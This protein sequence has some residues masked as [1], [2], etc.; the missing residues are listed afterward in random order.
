MITAAAPP[1]VDCIQWVPRRFA[2]GNAPTTIADLVF[3]SGVFE[4]IAAHLERRPDESG[5]GALVGRVF[6]DPTCE[7]RWARVDGIVP[8]ERPLAEEA[9]A[10]AIAG[11]FV[12][13]A[14]EI[15]IRDGST[16]LGWYRLHVGT[17]LYLSPEEARFHEARF[18]DPWGFALILAG[19]AER[20]SG[21]VFQRTVRDG[22]SRSVYT[23]FYELSGPAEGR[24]PVARPT[25]LAWGNYQTETRVVRETSV[26]EREPF[27]VAT[28]PE[29]DPAL[30][31]GQVP[32]RRGRE[33]PTALP[34]LEGTDAEWEKRQ[35]Q[36]SLTAVGR[37]LG[38]STLGPPRAPTTSWTPARLAPLAPQGPAEPAE[39]VETSVPR[40]RPV[41]VA[42]G[43]S[44][45]GLVGRSRRRRS[46]ALG[47]VLA[48]AA[49]FALMASAGWMGRRMLADR[50]PGHG[51]DRTGSATAAISTGDLFVSRAS[52]DPPAVVDSTVTTAAG[53][54]SDSGVVVDPAPIEGGEDPA[55]LAGD[56][57]SPPIAT[58]RAP[59]IVP[60]PDPFSIVVDDPAT[61]TYDNALSIFR[62]EIARYDQTRA[63]FDRGD[64]T[65]NPL[66]LSYRGVLDAYARLGRRFA[67]TGPSP[68]E[69]L[70]QA[71]E[72]A[73][74]QFTVTRTHYE[75]T[76]CPM[77]IGN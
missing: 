8:R 77:P 62:A 48:A 7:R 61:A 9:D 46:R 64:A 60:A 5:I 31:R 37:T 40:A 73:E 30:A 10:V 13:V 47:R 52:M 54:P 23:P 25:A 51:Q 58:P 68:P 33:T 35:I 69:D 1:Y 76:D 12:E 57:G 21:G 45:S 36:R 43:P 29:L 2:A 20:R 72:A 32:H 26:V 28:I 42:T 11:A 6:E 17:G 75:L 63:E 15:R 27:A 41:P 65:C 74:R 50:M 44:A 38:S 49:G 66:N 70:V 56:S 24:D 16:V 14:P 34:L 22:L 4:Q 71:N 55:T 59:E 3:R 67:E 18:P 53:V 39:A 19:A